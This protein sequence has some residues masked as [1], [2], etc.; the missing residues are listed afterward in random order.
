VIISV[1]GTGIIGSAIVKSL[2][3]S[4]FTQKIIATRR[5]I[6][7][8]REL[9]KL[10]I[11][12]TENNKHAADEADLV[13]ICV[14]PLD[15]KEV[16]NEIKN[17]IESKLVVSVAAAVPIDF[18]KSIAPRAKFIRAMPNIGILVGEAFIAYCADSEVNSDDK[19]KVEKIFGTLGK[20]REVD[21]KYMD[22]ITG[23]SGSGPAY[24]S[25]VIE[26][27]M[28]AGLKVGLPRDLSL[29]SSAQTVLGTGKLIL[30]TNK[31][32]AELKDM[33]VTPAGTT[34]EG[35]YEIE[36][37]GIRTSIMRA[38]EAATNKSKKITKKAFIN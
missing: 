14:K 38:V 2:S 27:L 23:L 17:E 10:G 6:D 18:L 8:I 21:E 37:G 31:H 35:I 26:A 28:Y 33:V 32:L 9:E 16:L 4:D 13:I 25:I 1:I 29:L 20:C 12:L 30:E 3:K 24:I 22:A 5:N 11:T 19:R 36:E 34:I 15:I 7:K